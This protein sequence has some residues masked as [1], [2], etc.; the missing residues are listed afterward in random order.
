MGYTESEIQ[1]CWPQKGEAATRGLALGKATL[2]FSC[3]GWTMSSS[4]NRCFLF[5]GVLSVCGVIDFPQT[6][7]ARPVVSERRPSID[8]FWDLA[9]I[10][11]AAPANNAGAFRRSDSNVSPAVPSTRQWPSPGE[12]VEGASKP[13]IRVPKNG[14][15]R[16]FW[17]GTLPPPPKKKNTKGSFGFAWQLSQKGPLKRKNIHP[18][19]PL[20]DLS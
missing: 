13:W 19:W 4:F 12:S 17:W 2:S 7:T 5:Q 16:G 15:K 3:L 14:R 11:L 8:I 10:S 9:Q 18:P 1:W 6:P 20:V